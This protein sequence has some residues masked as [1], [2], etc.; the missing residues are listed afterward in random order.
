MS[1]FKRARYEKSD[2]RP[3]KEPIAVPE[4]PYIP[5]FLSF[6]D[7]LDDHHDRRERI[8]KAS[9]DTLRWVKKM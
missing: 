5:M 4:G 6:R 2:N 3:P 7:D 8:I 9:R 1:G